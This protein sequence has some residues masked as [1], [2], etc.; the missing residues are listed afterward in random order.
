MPATS[1]APWIITISFFSPCRENIYFIQEMSKAFS[2]DRLLDS[3]ERKIAQSLPFSQTLLTSS[4]IEAQRSPTDGAPSI[5]SEIPSI[6]GSSSS[7]P[8]AND[9]MCCLPLEGASP[10]L[11]S[12]SPL[13]YL[14]YLRFLSAQLGDMAPTMGVFNELF[15]HGGD[16]TEQPKSLP[17]EVL[18][19]PA[20][21]DYTSHHHHGLTSPLPHSL[22]STEDAY[23]EKCSVLQAP[24]MDIGD[25]L[26]R[27][28]QASQDGSVDDPTDFY[29]RCNRPR[30]SRTTF[31]T[32]QLHVL[33]AA[34]SI[35][36]YPDV[37]MR[38][39]LASQLKLSDGRVQLHAYRL[40]C[41]IHRRPGA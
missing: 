32:L 11:I 41:L 30:R 20:V 24:K 8:P 15:T 34:F 3:P 4:P 9:A 40:F 38:D 12:V 37:T 25:F 26:S 31:T 5:K 7:S 28:D 35:N 16:A 27:G 17:L 39:Q 23:S 33:E 13:A 2:I 22:S 36:H 14:H 6:G 1:I 21:V 29:V 19:K 18:A 10:P